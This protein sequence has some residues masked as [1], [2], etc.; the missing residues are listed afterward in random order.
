M[1]LTVDDE[2]RLERFQSMND[3][4][5]QKIREYENEIQELDKKITTVWLDV[6][7]MREL[8]TPNQNQ[9]IKFVNMPGFEYSV[10]TPE[11]AKAGISADYYNGYM[12]KYLFTKGKSYITLGAFKAVNVPQ[13][14]TLMYSDIFNFSF[15]QDFYSRHLGRGGRKFLNLYSGYHVGFMACTGEKSS[16]NTVYV[17]PAVGLELYKNNFMLL[18]TKMTYILPFTENLNMRGLQFAA[19]LNFVF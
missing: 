17:S 14:D 19:S 5:E 12:L 9:K 18:D 1:A 7:L 2:I 16:L 4:D 10:F 8:T 6:A 3:E 13:N 15:G 11:N